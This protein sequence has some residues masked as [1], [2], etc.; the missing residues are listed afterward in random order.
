MVFLRQDGPRERKPPLLPHRAASNRCMSR[1]T[2]RAA[3]LAVL[4]STTFAAAQSRLGTARD[5]PV[6]RLETVATFNGPMPTGVT[7]SR[8]NRIFVNFPR[9][10]DDVPYTVAEIVHGKTIAYPDAAMNDWPGRK[11]PDPAHYSNRQDNENHFVSV[12]SVVVDPA[13]RLWVLD[14]GS[15]LLKNAVPGGPKLVAIDL[16]TNKIIKRILLPANIAGPTSYL[17]D[18]RFDLRQGSTAGSDGVRGIAYITDSSE[19]GPTGFVIVDLA[20]GQAWRKLDNHASVKAE[21]GFVMFALGRPPYKTEPSQPAKPS[22]FNNDSIAI[23]S[24]GAHLFY[25]PVSASKLYSVPTASLLDRNLADSALA[26]QVMLVS[27]KESSDGLESDAAGSV[28]S[29][30]PASGS[31]LG[32]SPNLAFANGVEV[33]TLVHDPRLLWP[34]T[35]SLSDDGYLYVTANQLYNQPSMHNGKDLRQKP[36]ALFRI[37]VDAKPVRLQ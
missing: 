12:Q 34:D 11:S 10:G 4:A 15:P 23:S 36:Y 16:N 18:V 3:L 31:I 25:C 20:T 5:Q 19:R 32:L 29:T 27:G 35:L 17:N 9:W 2:V 7:V 26:S 24:D 6:G 37:K 33:T 21:P 30:A 13:N 1:H 8:N 22:V 14:T 28:Y